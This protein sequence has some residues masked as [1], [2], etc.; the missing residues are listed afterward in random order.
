MTVVFAGGEQDAFTF[1]GNVV[2]ST[3]VSK[4]DTKSE[5]VQEE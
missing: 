1:V 5:A 3:D 4:M 2:T